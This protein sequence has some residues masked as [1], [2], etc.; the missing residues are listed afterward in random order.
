LYD[1]LNVLSDL[2]LSIRDDFSKYHKRVPESRIREV[3]ASIGKPTSGKGN[4]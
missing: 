4:A 1:A 3:F 2:A